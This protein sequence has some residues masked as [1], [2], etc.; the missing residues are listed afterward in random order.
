[1]STNTS[2]EAELIY[3]AVRNNSRVILYT[4]V[5][6]RGDE[7]GHRDQ[8]M[9]DDLWAISTDELTRLRDLATYNQR[10]LDEAKSAPFE[11]EFGHKVYAHNTVD[12]WCCACE[13]DQA[14]MQGKIDEA[15]ARGYNDRDTDHEK[16]KLNSQ[17]TNKGDN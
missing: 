9:R 10:K 2:D 8:T 14:F 4:D 12:N 13:A 3:K 16:S 17:Q 5:M 15:Y 6:G 1:M 11:C 7:E